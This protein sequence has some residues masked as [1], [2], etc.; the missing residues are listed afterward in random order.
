[1]TTLLHTSVYISST[2]HDRATVEWCRRVIG[3]VDAHMP[4]QAS[5]LW[6]WHRNCIYL[7]QD[8]TH[9]CVFRFVDARHKLMFDLAWGHLGVYHTSAELQAAIQKYQDS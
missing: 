9:C 5:R 8:S 2:A 7:K 1:M 3:T 4:L 6:S